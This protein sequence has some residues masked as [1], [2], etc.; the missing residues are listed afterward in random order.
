MGYYKLKDV[1]H[2]SP[3]PFMQASEE[4]KAAVSAEAIARAKKI[5][6]VRIRSF[7]YI[8]ITILNLAYLSYF[9]FGFL[10]KPI[11]INKKTLTT[12]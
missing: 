11:L 1:R 12:M 6:K 8:A 4:A 2:L 7:T 9:V 5:S 3:L 10:K